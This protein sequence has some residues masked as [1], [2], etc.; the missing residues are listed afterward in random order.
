[1]RLL[2]LLAL[3][4]TV[5]A[6]PN[7]TRVTSWRYRVAGPG[8]SVGALELTGLDDVWPVLAAVGQNSSV[9]QADVFFDHAS[10]DSSESKLSSVP[11]CAVV[12][13]V[14]GPSETLACRA[15]RP[16]LQTPCATTDL[17]LRVTPAHRRRRDQGGRRATSWCPT[18]TPRRS[19]CTSS[20]SYWHCSIRSAS[21]VPGLAT[22]LL[23]CARSWG[24]K[25]LGG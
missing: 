13:R 15:R 19:A 5:A 16:N 24:L 22:R 12:E 3:L 17:A 21:S 9:N 1:M 18:A 7:A 20:S 8:C 11:G 10:L 25:A 4:T 6:V 2:A 23:C 14:Q